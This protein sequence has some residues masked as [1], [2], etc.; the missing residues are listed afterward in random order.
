VQ[1][2][3]GDEV[4]RRLA[5]VGVELAGEADARRRAA[6]G[7]GDEVVEVAVRGLRELE[8]AEADVVQGLVVEDVP[9]REG[10]GARR[11]K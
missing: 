1:A 4:D 5:E 8:G 3:E 11:V 7:R 2:G 9:E 6:H 10:G